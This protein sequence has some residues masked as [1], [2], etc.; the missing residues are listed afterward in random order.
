MCIIIKTD[1]YIHI[2]PFTKQKKMGSFSSFNSNFGFNL[3]WLV[4]LF[5]LIHSLNLITISVEANSKKVLQKKLDVNIENFKHINN[6]DMDKKNIESIENIENDDVSAWTIHTLSEMPGYSLRI[7]KQNDDLC[8]STVDQYVG[9]IDVI[10]TNTNVPPSTNPTDKHFFFWFF[11]SRNDPSTDPLLL[12]LNGGPGCSSMT[13]LLMELGPCQVAP[14]GNGT[15]NNPYSWN[16][17][18]NVIFLDQP[19][20][21]GFSYSEEAE[22]VVDTVSAAEDVYAFLEL[23]ITKFKKYSKLPFHITGES[24]AGH[25]IPAIGNKIFKENQLIKDK[26]TEKV[27]INLT[28]LAIGNGLTDPLVQYG[29]YADFAADTTYGPILSEDTITDMRSK[30]QTCSKLI[31]SCYNYENRFSC[32]P[33]GLYCNNALIMPF[34][35][36]GLNI[37]DIRKKCDREK[38]PLCYDIMNDIDDY[39]NNPNVQKSLGVDRKFESCKMDINGRFAMAGDWMKPYVRDLPELLESGINVLIYAGDADF[40]CNWI[41]NKAWITQLEWSG[42][43][44]FLN[45]EDK[46]VKS[47]ITGKVAGLV[48]KFKNLSFYRIYEAGHMVPYDQPEHSSEMIDEWISN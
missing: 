43:K 20:N 26:K 30:Y 34:Q 32:V 33:A 41:G 13:G 18:A 14:G 9:Y 36:T 22:Q 37:Y 4:S 7:K 45:A 48:R 40:I 38:N 42:H 17:K 39:L 8:D 5:L 2:T 28:S 15:I 21:V 29:Y 16:N 11:E 46:E 6:N 44:E 10:S 1:T 35:S 23:F 47:K 3:K 19:I 25:Y 24:Y 27:K 12:W 31:E